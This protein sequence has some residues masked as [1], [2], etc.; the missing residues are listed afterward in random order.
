MQGTLLAALEEAKRKQ[1]KSCP[2]AP[3]ALS[4][5]GEAEMLTTSWRETP[6]LWR[7]QGPRGDKTPS[8]ESLVLT[9]ESRQ[10]SDLPQCWYV[11]DPGS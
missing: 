6:G 5:V 7:I 3:R 8:R 11:L 9:P 4:L 2:H 10:H 1:G